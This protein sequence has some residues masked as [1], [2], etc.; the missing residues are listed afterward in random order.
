MNFGFF[1][2]PVHHPSK[3]LE[4]TIKEDM[5]TVITADQLG[6][7][8]GW[9]GEH[10]TIPWENL[11]APDLFIAQAFAKTQNIKLGTGVV[12]LQLHD[13]KMLAHR[14][15]MLDHLS[16]GR[17]Y[18]GVGTGGVPTE[19]ELFEVE[20][21]KR[22]ARAAEVL[23]VVLKLWE[24][25]GPFEYN[26]EFYQVKATSPFPELGLGLW[27]KPYQKPHPAHRRRRRQP[28]LLHHRV[29]WRKRLDSPHHRHPPIGAPPHPLGSLPAWRRQRRPRRR[30]PRLA[31]LPRHPRRRDHR[32]SPQRRPQ[33]WHGTQLR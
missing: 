30:P 33:P 17:F 8:E 11:P 26:G 10:F 19:F 12:L 1:M 2:M 28:Q 27:L 29:G 21:D 24:A 3:G 6:Y 25:E 23:D 18:L 31:R 14:L 9:I 4:R 13:P 20:E 32:R 7:H 22:H 15:A 16:E 5:Q